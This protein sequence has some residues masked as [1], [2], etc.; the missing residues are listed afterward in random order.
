MSEPRKQHYVPQVYLKNFSY[1]SRSEDKIFVLSN[2]SSKIYLANVRDTAAERHFYTVDSIKD[3]YV[4]ERCYAETV[5]PLLGD[6]LRKIRQRCENHLIQ[7]NAV[8]LSYEEKEKLALS[9]IFQFL[10]GKHTR[11][12]ER[13]IYQEV[14]PDIIKDAYKKF[15]PIDE[16]KEKVISSFASDESFF[17]QIAMQ[18]NFNYESIE[19]YLKVILVRSFIF[20]KIVGD[21]NFVT[22]DNP[23]VVM[24]LKNYNVAPFRNGL[25]EAHN[26]IYYPISSKLLLVAYHP[27]VFLGIF[28]KSDCCI[29]LIDSKRDI[30]F[31][32]F[33][34]KKQKEHCDNY[35]Y[36]GSRDVLESIQ[37]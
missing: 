30:D 14:L 7:N 11:N 34:N 26:A 32:L 18:T 8:I 31:I 6:V 5:E 35:V 3:K 25:I 23:V 27:D 12:F 9:I 24:N 22:S 19:K 28:K 33:Q 2:N 15:S 13:K 17:K 29:E 36:A 20:Y 4:W 10:R 1:Q 21:A 37:N 16:K